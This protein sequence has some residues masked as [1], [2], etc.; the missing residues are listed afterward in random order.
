MPTF[1][2][3]FINPSSGRKNKKTGRA[4]D[5]DELR[6]ILTENG[7]EPI[8]V[9]LLPEPEAT[10]RQIDYLRDLTGYAPHGLTLKEAS[11]LIDN[12]LGKRTTADPADFDIAKNLKIEVTQYASKKA[13]H[14]AIFYEMQSRGLPAF[15]AWFTYRVYRDEFDRRDDGIRDPLDPAFIEIGQSI[16]DDVRL[17]AS[18]KRIASRSSVHFRWFGLLRTPDGMEM[19]R[20]GDKSDVYKFVVDEL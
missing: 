15:A 12:A 2:Y 18:F 11:N 9:I 17:T 10:E 5:E 3:R 6:A 7:I 8:E 13:I 20:D 19:H 14:E 16:V 4:F 1:E